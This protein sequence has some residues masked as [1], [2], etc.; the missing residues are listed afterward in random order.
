MTLTFDQLEQEALALPDA[1]RAELAKHLWETLEP[2]VDPEVEAA[3]MS[4]AQRRM[5]ELRSGRVQ[6]IPGDKVMAR[7][8]QKLPA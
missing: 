5:E 6:G 3:W 1:Q 4:E 8:R 2:A 7:I